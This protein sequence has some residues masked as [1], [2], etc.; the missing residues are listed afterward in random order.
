MPYTDD[1]PFDMAYMQMEQER[2]KA[3]RPNLATLKL[4]IEKQLRML[5]MERENIDRQIYFLKNILQD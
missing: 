2:R 1:T 3:H 5:Q 4:P